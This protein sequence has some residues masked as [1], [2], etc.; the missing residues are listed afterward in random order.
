[1]LIYTFW[2][3]NISCMLETVYYNGRMSFLIYNVII[4]LSLRGLVSTTIVVQNNII[5]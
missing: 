1:M 3:E 4:L 5:V 2:G